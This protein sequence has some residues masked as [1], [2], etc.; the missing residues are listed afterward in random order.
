MDPLGALIPQLPE[1]RLGELRTRN[2]WTANLD[3]TQ[4]QYWSLRPLL[5][6]TCLSMRHYKA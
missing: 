6:M 2:L 1:L 5:L 3:T 4:L